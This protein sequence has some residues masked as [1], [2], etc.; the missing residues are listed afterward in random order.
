MSSFLI[1]TS[2]H[3]HV[4]LDSETVRLF[5]ASRT[6]G[7]QFLNGKLVWEILFVS[8]IIDLQ[9]LH[10]LKE[11]IWYWMMWLAEGMEEEVVMVYLQTLSQPSFEIEGIHRKPQ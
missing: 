5:L 2:F 3:A 6:F 11:M 7:R 10:H 8:W 4:L 1:T 9:M